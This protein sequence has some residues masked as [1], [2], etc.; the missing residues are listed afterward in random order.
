MD[1]RIETSQPFAAPH[2]LVIP[3]KR[4]DTSPL[5]SARTHSPERF[6]HE[7]FEEVDEF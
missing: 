3:Q 2:M 1:D 6:W 4:E 7:Y 5:R